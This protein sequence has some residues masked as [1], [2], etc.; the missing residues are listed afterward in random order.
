MTGIEAFNLLANGDA[1]KERMLIQIITRSC[2]VGCRLVVS[3]MDLNDNDVRIKTKKGF[4]PAVVTHLS[5]E[6]KREVTS[7]AHTEFLTALKLAEIAEEHRS[8]E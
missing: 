7:G 8:K 4:L 3:A 6:M 1:E 2:I 5:K